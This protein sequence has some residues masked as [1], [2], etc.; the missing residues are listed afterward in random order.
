MAL[1][2][3]ILLLFGVPCSEERI[4]DIE[5]WAILD[6]VTTEYAL[7][8][9]FARLARYNSERISDISLF[10][11]LFNESYS[12]KISAPIVHSDSHEQNG[13]R[14][15][16]LRIQGDSVFSRAE[17]Q[18][19]KISDEVIANIGTRYEYLFDI[20]YLGFKKIDKNLLEK[21]T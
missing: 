2:G 8:L 9:W 14:L 18:K 4:K 10:D 19:I 5:E 12:V 15:P 16:M 20:E 13:H 1:N 3:E 6:E 17:G 21:E 7:E 11:R